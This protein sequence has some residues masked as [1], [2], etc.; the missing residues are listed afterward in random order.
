MSFRLLID[1]CLSPELVRLAIDAGHVESTCLRDRGLLGAKDWELMVYVVASD[2]T[3]VT[4]NAVDFRGEGAAAP[5][6]LH[7][8]QGVHAG[9]ICL[10]S[11]HPLDIDRQCDLFRIALGE[12]AAVSDLVNQA[13]EV[14]EDE[15]GNVI[16][17]TYDI[18][19]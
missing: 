13:L 18:P 11:F 19:R 6:G 17:Q 8:K 3:L 12:L 10:D 5:G 1:E 9:L 16:V 14:Y 15:A 2:F 7:A 4:N